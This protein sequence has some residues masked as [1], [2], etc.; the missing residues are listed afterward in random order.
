MKPVV[1]A[2]SVVSVLGV[3]SLALVARPQYGGVLHVEMPATIRTLD[4]TAAAADPSDA[5]A[6]ARL[7]P[8][9]FET[10]VAADADG[11]LAP[12]LAVSWDHDARAVR[13]RFRLRSD[14][15]LHDGSILEASQVAAALRGA[16]AWK[17]SADGDTLLVES[18]REAPDLLWELA[19]VRYAVV[20]RRGPTE[21]MGTGPFRV[22]RFQSSH[23]VLR[24]HEDYWSGRPF[25]DT[26][27]IAM[28]QS[29]ADQL[30]SLELGRADLASITPSDAPR[31][32]Q[33][34]LRIAASRPIDLVA[35]VFEEHRALPGGQ[36]LRNAV[37]AAI[38]RPSL[39]TLLL[40]RW[41][42][43][44]A[45]MLP[46]WLSGYASL[47]SA[48]HDRAA[49]RALVTAL[50]AAQRSVALRVES[51]A[52]VDRVIADRIAVDAR[53][54]GLAIK[55]DPADSLAPRPDVRLV[56]VKLEATS[57]DRAL[58]AALTALGPRASRV[59]PVDA[60]VPAGAP[61]EDVFRLERA[62]LEPRVI[63]PIVHL[64]ELYALGAHVEAWN[65]PIVLPSGA[66]DFG[67]VW[68]RADKP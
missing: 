7:L 51:P 2:V 65:G 20:V 45:T 21:M 67:N 27:D 12:G 48:G 62:L 26:V 25:V 60:T 10:L 15:R 57:P 44:A 35:L 13:W 63:V 37:A 33:R 39:C 8:L 55:I 53:D 23:L 34:G 24:A 42:Q 17:V 50:P 14:V 32:S 22:E 52:P 6:R 46:D 18:D 64:P 19:T 61:L 59:L 4:P 11:G 54:V 41:A 31:L 68:V 16:A 66:W 5:L 38:D 1:F 36:P 56:H 30:A 40:Q 47:F 58:A 43:P 28:G 3:S 9:V 29:P 49:A